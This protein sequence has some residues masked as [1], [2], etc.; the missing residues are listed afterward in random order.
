MHKLLVVGPSW[1]GDT[2]LA[3]PLL[4]LLRERRTDTEIHFLAPPWTA[5]LVQR[6]PEVAKVI[7]NPFGHGVLSLIERYRFGRNLRP[8]QYDG[9]LVLPNSLKSALIPWLAGIPLR[10]GYQ[11]E[12]RYGLLNDRRGL[13][14]AALPQMVQRFAA[15]G[16]GRN[17]ALPEKLPSPRLTSSPEQQHAVAARLN[18][19]TGVSPFVFCPGAEYGPAKRWPP[20]HFSLLARQLLDAD[21]CVWI[22]GSPKDI[23]IADAINAGADGRCFNLCGQTSLAEAVDLL[24]MARGVISNDSGLMHVAA[25]VGRPLI[26][27]YGSSSPVFTPPISSQARVLSLTLECSPCFR[28]HCPL[29]HF[30]CMRDLT[31]A[32]VLAALK[33]SGMLHRA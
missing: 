31:P 3:Q 28:R 21:Q 24:A 15:L 32:Q 12:M 18:L 10:T 14:A 17:E 1:V 29:D 2:V 33:E 11:G 22:L 27:L 5:P 13:D 20:E 4:M 16:L 19:G 7:V 30:R 8:E 23:A 6:M 25:A 26:A 9:C